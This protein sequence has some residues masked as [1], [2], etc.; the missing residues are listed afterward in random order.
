MKKTWI[1]AVRVSREILRDPL[2]LVFGIGFPI[3][4]LL[5]LTAIEQNIPVEMFVLSELTPGIAMFGASFLSLF[6]AQLIARDRASF[7]L[8]RMFT[9]PMRA[10]HFILGY[11]LPLFPMAL[12]QGGIVYGVALILGLKPTWGL[13][14]AVLALLPIAAIYIG[15]GLLL[16]SLLPEKAATVLSGTLL[17]NLSAW[18]SGT[19]F[20]LELVGEGFRIF[21]EC[22][23]FA[24]AT[25]L[26]R[27]LL[28]LDFSDAVLHVAVVGGYAALI[29]VGA[30]LAFHKSMKQ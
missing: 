13:I 4:L 24:H 2:S 8:G 15:L 16:G 14:P 27:A 22:L 21:A 6:S 10:Y 23:P 29:L 9:T 1:W 11:A 3:V 17:T 26:G 30:V 19:W 7:V 28:A 25:D 18:F 5:L 20:S 12:A